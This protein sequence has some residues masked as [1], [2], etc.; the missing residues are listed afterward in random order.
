MKVD[1]AVTVTFRGLL[2]FVFR[3]GQTHGVDPRQIFARNHLAEIPAQRSVGPGKVVNLFKLVGLVQNN[4]QFV[5][6]ARQGVEQDRQGLARGAG[7]VGIKE[8]ADN[9][10]AVGEPAHD[11]REIVAAVHGRGVAVVV[12]VGTVVVVEHH[13][14]VIGGSVNHAR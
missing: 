11:A 6:H 2:I 5:V 4:Q 8:Q 13:A 12:T 7:F 3:H 9:V 14:R 1:V 10:G